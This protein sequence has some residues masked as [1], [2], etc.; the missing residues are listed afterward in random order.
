LITCGLFIYAFFKSLDTHI[1]VT[2]PY[3]KYEVWNVNSSLFT[4]KRKKQLV[5]GTSHFFRMAMLHSL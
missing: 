2:A 4:E 5:L 1:K 3:S